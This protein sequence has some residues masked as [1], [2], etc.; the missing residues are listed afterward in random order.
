MSDVNPQDND[1]TESSGD[2][3]EVQDSVLARLIRLEEE[4]SQ[5]RKQLENEKKQREEYDRKRQEE[6][7][8]LTQTIKR[9]TT[10]G[11]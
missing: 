9:L 7:N 5:I 3:P 2:V 4:N 6:I 10:A 11:V 8:K 1:E